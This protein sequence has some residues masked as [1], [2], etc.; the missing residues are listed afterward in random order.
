M[1]PYVTYSNG[2]KHTALESPDHI[3]DDGVLVFVVGYSGSG[4]EMCKHLTLDEY[5]RRATEKIGSGELEVVDGK[6][7]WVQQEI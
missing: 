3:G 2:V 7:F 1:T 4:A 6:Y 5:K